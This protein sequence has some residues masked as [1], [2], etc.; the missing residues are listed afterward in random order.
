MMKV[1]TRIIAGYGVLILLTVAVLTYQVLMIQQL[2]AINSKLSEVNVG[3]ALTSLYLQFDEGLVEEYALKYYG[4][5][6][7]QYKEQFRGAGIDLEE[8]LK[9]L[10]LTA[11]SPPEVKALEGVTM[12]WRAVQKTIE[13]EEKLSQSPELSTRLN[14]QLASLREASVPVKD[15]AQ[16][17]ITEVAKLSSETATHAVQVSK[18]AAGAALLLSILV[19]APIVW[20][21]LTR[22]RELG[23]AT[24]VVAAGKFDHRL[25]ASGTDEFADL[26][27]DFNTMARKLGEIDQMKKD[28]VSHVSHDLKGPL[29]STRETVHLLLEGIP[30]PL[31]DKQR[32]LLDLCLKSSER[33]SAMIGNLLDVS[34]MEA[35]M[36]DYKM[37]ACDLIPLARSA[38]SELE[39]LAHEK[40]MDLVVESAVSICWVECD[41]GRITQVISNLI[42]NAIKFSPE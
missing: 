5:G 30:G 37:E 26:A 40:K 27:R 29:A 34:R 18:I 16:N 21:I 32:R 28:F 8:D 7:S 31:N 36:M 2:H 6:D 10:Q 11:T 23:R 41:H 22:L 14:D 3:N 35:G 17:A 33:L 38:A 19:S 24:R 15:A 1:S 25:P 12:A 9:K 42:E 13:S 4:T 39:G 20:S